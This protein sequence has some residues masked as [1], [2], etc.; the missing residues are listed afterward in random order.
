MSTAPVLASRDGATGIVELARP[1]KYNALSRDCFRLIGEALAKFEA[2]RSV[3]ALLIRAQGK[4]FCTGADL[5]QVGGF[6]SVGA[7]SAVNSRIGHDVLKALEA[8]RLPV[9]A[10]VQGLAL[11]GGIE[12]V[13]A[14]DVVIAGETARLGDQHAHFGLIPGWGGSQRLPRIVGLR[15]SLDLFFTAR[16]LDAA[17]ALD[18]GLVNQVVPDDALQ[19]AALDYCTAL[20]GRNPDGLALMKKLARE[21]LDGSLGAGLDMELAAVPPFVESDNVQEGVRA[22]NE[23]REPV[24]Q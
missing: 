24:F 10:A 11:A 18:W 5:E 23:K 9:I 13:L 22:F 8:S 19:Q 12:L 16:W 21:G 4:N 20:A 2:D 15:R 6:G 1:E 17:T 14:C 3:R 7:E